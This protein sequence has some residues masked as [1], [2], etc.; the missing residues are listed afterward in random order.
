M[1]LSAE[2][3]RERIKSPTNNESIRQAIKYESRLEFH[4]QKVVDERY[5]SKY[6]WSFKSWINQVLTDDKY[7]RFL[8]LVRLPFSNVEF[9]DGIFSEF[10]KVFDTNNPYREDVFSDNDNEVFFKKWYEEN[11]G[12]Y[13]RQHSLEIL[14]T[15]PCSVMYID[16]TAVDNV[17]MPTCM[18]INM[19]DV[20]DVVNN[21]DNKCE[22]FIFKTYNYQIEDEIFE[23]VAVQVDD[24]YCR[25]FTMDNDPRLV[26]EIEH[27]YGQTP[28]RSFWS[29]NLNHND[30]IIKDNPIAGSLG[31]LDYLLLKTVGKDYANLYASY[32]IVV[33]TEIHC[34]YTDFA[35]NKK[36]QDGWLVDAGGLYNADSHNGINKPTVPEPCPKCAGK[37]T[38]FAGNE[39]TVPAPTVDNP[40][41]KD[42]VKFV[43]IPTDSLE[44]IQTELAKYKEGIWLNSVGK[45][46]DLIGKES[47]NE[48]Q[49]NAAFESKKTVL[50]NIA[51]NLAKAEQWKRSM[52]AKILF[53]NTFIESVV[54][55]GDEFFI[56]SLED[57]QKEKETAKKNG[58]SNSEL[59]AIQKQIINTKFKNNPKI[60]EKMNLL[61]NLEPFPTSSIQE[62]RE[63]FNDGIVL[64][65]DVIKKIRFQNYI[66]QFERENGDIL[67]FGSEQD[68]NNQV[69]LINQTI[70]NYV[71]NDVRRYQDPSESRP[72][73]GNL[74]EE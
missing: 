18:F 12:D 71:T 36:C 46:T 72:V 29:S 10:E 55:Y 60:K 58:A 67:E 23:E 16:A 19:R 69:K 49:V 74:Q 73:D 52:M 59:M 51:K 64:K 5:L 11:Y 20:I 45:A 1:I 50:L 66:D 25:V 40:E 68:F 30:Y 62:V 27:D 7:N 17:K 53:P 35:N 61:L 48:K 56:R 9:T 47:M 15:N 3:A 24:K 28:A 22:Y 2:Q 70:D 34:D 41:I 63:M 8:Q 37:R 39:V 42:P 32:P 43:P 26:K 33:H 21:K 54:D 6:W 44:F 31:N 13:F 38:M 4:T 14:K 65:E 57:L